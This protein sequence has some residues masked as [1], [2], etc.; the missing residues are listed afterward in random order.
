MINRLKNALA[1]AL[2]QLFAPEIKR[3][4]DEIA[5]RDN[6]IKE[7][8]QKIAE[9]EAKIPPDNMIDAGR[10]WVKKLADGSIDTIPYCY[11]CKT[12]MNI[13]A[14]AMTGKTKNTHFQCAN[15]LCKFLL[16]W[17]EDI[18]R[19]LRS[20]GAQADWLDRPASG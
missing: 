14:S 12:P 9:L 8:E 11:L 1:A 2:A 17:G 15:S 18:L 5:K 19:I 7:L 6:R 20:H 4:L 3:L 10:F 16:P 13:Y